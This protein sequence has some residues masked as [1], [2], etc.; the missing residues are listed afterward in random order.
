MF[1][2]SHNTLRQNGLTNRICPHL[3]HISLTLRAYLLD[4]A[5]RTRDRLR[6]VE[7][8]ELAPTFEPLA[9]QRNAVPKL[10]CLASNDGA[11]E[12][13]VLSKLLP[14]WG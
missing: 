2:G 11:A 14:I 13:D 12:I 9:P 5:I 3:N 1:H 4:A 8:R 10:L 6:C 7:V